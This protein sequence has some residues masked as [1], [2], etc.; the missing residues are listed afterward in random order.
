MAEEFTRCSAGIIHLFFVV[1][2]PIAGLQRPIVKLKIVGTASFL[3]ASWRSLKEDPNK[4]LTIRFCSKLSVK[5]STQTRECFEG[6]KHSLFIFISHSLL[7][8]G[9]WVNLKMLTDCLWILS[10]FPLKFTVNLKLKQFQI[11]RKQWRHKFSDNFPDRSTITKD[12]KQW[13]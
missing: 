6:V 9:F 13:F 12:K 2:C 11:S 5:C 8:F 10:G 4:L 3:S 1:F 7:R